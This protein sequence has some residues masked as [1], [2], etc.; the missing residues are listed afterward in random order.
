M[1]TDAGIQTWRYL[2]NVT[3]P[4]LHP[5]PGLRVYY[6]SESMLWL[7]HLLPLCADF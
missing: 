4:D 2:Y 1:Y 5:L 6:G 7:F 3:F